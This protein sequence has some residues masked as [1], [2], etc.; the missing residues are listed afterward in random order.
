MCPSVLS[1]VWVAPGEPHLPASGLQMCG[2]VCG[3]KSKAATLSRMQAGS[4][5][6]KFEH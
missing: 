2:Q 3:I 1:L 5:R 6:N 4:S